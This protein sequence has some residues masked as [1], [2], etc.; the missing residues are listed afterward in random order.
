[1]NGA[2]YSAFLTNCHVINLDR[3]ACDILTFLIGAIF[4]L[5]VFAFHEWEFPWKRKVFLLSIERWLLLGKWEKLIILQ[6][7]HDWRKAIKKALRMEYTP[8]LPYLHCS[9]RALEISHYDHVLSS[10]VP[11]VVSM[12]Q[13]PC[14]LPRH[15]QAL[16][17]PA[18]IRRPMHLLRATHRRAWMVNRVMAA[19]HHDS[20]H[21]RIVH[22]H[23][24]NAS[25]MFAIG[26]QYRHLWQLVA[27]IHVYGP[28]I[29]CNLLGDIERLN[30]QHRQKSEIKMHTER[31]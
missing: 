15:R 13:C 10:F 2:L 9:Q 3:V 27:L 26:Y 22:A 28:R 6:S 25:V 21:N 1:M 12:V 16:V 5:I 30:L 20:D 29:D 8:N 31:N 7:N 24:A 23:T 19:H 14:L 11:I 17:A 4:V 18:T